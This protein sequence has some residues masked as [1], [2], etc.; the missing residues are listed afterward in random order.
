[1]VECKFYALASS[2]YRSSFIAT[3][4]ETIGIDNYTRETLDQVV[5]RKR[6]SAK[7]GLSEDALSVYVYVEPLPTIH[8]ASHR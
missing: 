2:L 8:R 6:V 1:M 5:M 4:S 3:T 7:W